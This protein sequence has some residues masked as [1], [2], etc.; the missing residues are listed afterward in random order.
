MMFQTMI[1]MN[2]DRAILEKTGMF[3]LPQTSDMIGRRMNHFNI[4]QGSD[5][6]HMAEWHNSIQKLVEQ[7]RLGI[8]ITISTDHR[9]AESQSS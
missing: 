4:L 5:P 6:R 8:P 2:K 1:G 9:D 3:P 7:I